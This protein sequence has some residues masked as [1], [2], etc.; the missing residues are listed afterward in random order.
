MSV[1]EEK[2]KYFSEYALKLDKDQ[3]NAVKRLGELF[4]E[5][6]VSIDCNQLRF[7]HSHIAEK[8]RLG[9]VKGYNARILEVDGIDTRDV[10][11][12]AWIDEV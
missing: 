8:Y 5:A 11:Y 9:Y 10:P 4:K 7:I 1:S 3:E 2:K 12:H 6:G